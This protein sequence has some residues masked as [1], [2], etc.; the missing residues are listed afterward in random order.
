MSYKYDKNY[1]RAVS[2]TGWFRK[3]TMQKRLDRIWKEIKIWENK[4]VLDVGCSGGMLQYL[5]SQHCLEIYGL[6][7]NNHVLKATDIEGRYICGDAMRM[8]LKSNYFDVVICS[9]L[10]EHL[11]SVY[12]CLDE[13]RRVSKTGAKIFI[14]YPVELFRGATC[15]P[16]VLL[17]GQRLSLIRKIHLHKLSLRRL[18]NFFK[19]TNLK[20]LKHKLI[21]A[22][23]PMYMAIIQNKE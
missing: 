23:Q 1:K 15:I 7:I 22:L 12:S 20:L 4:R 3:I 14:L 13:M 2:E 11:P 18:K 21:F 9:H 6:D 17:N 10:L 16:D 8:P 5:L 19:R